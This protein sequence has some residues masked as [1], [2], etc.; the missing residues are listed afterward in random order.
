MSTKKLIQNIRGTR[1][2]YPPDM[3]KRRWFMETSRKVLE[4]YGYE[5]YDAPLLESMELYVAKSSPEIIERQAYVFE[6]RGGEKIVVRPEMTPSLARMVAAKQRELPSLLR[7]YSLPECWRYE[8][9]QKGRTRNFLQLNVDLLGSDAIEADI[10]IIES[11]LKLLESYG[12]DMRTIEVRVNDRMILK[13]ILEDAGGITITQEKALLRLLDE[14]DKLTS[15]EF[16]A[17]WNELGVSEAIRT[18]VFALLE[19]DSK[20][21]GESRIATIVEALVRRRWTQVRFDP[22]LIRGFEYYTST[23][24]EVFDTAGKLNRAVFGGGRYDK[25]I[26]D[27]GGLSMPC[28]G[29]AVSD[30]SIEALLKEQGK[31]MGESQRT[32]TTIIPF[33]SAEARAGDE[34]A[35]MLRDKGVAVALA[36]PPYDMKKQLKRAAQEGVA[37][38]ILLMPD[39]LANNQVVVKDMIRGE[40]AVVKIPALLEMIKKY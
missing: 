21:M 34:I 6:D 26:E 38:V 16:G 31:E 15:D 37:K 9:P 1:D 20:A 30:V 39:E 5:E 13:R 36:L 10:E 29:Y 27:M 32:M 35:T 8:R 22:T 28:I 23:V 18:A 24:F 19:S 11:A 25:L 4:G 14:R 7:W 33:S 2:L 40:Q 12:V 3:R 17:R